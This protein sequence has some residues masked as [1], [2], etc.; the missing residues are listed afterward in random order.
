MAGLFENLLQTLIAQPDTR[1]NLL[2]EALGRADPQQLQHPIND[3]RQLSLLKVEA[4]Q[5]ETYPDSGS[6]QV[7]MNLC[8]GIMG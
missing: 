5:T 4:N 8:L 6:P 7:V 3:L 1:L 2:V